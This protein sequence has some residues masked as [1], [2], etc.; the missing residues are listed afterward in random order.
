[1]ENKKPVY[2]SKS[3]I[4]ISV[5]IECSGPVPIDYSML[6]LGVCVVGNEDG[7]HDSDSQFYVEMKPISDKYVKEALEVCNF[8]LEELRSKACRHNRL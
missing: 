2:D 8:S 3:A 1:L 4:Y 6:S 7:D 5:D